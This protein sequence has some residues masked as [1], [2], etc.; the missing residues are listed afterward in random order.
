M[1]L[2]KRGLEVQKQVPVE[3][4]YDGVLMDVGFRIDL[5]VEKCLVVR[6]ESRWKIYCRF[7]R[8]N[9]GYLPKT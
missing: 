7:I 4:Y 3:V 8:R 5:L 1:S 9:Y 2:K 6:S